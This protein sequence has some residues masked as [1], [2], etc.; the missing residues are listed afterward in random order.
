M[1]IPCP[2]DSA[3]GTLDLQSSSYSLFFP[4]SLWGAVWVSPFFSYRALSSVDLL[5]EHQCLPFT[6]T[7]RPVEPNGILDTDIL[8]YRKAKPCS[9]HCYIHVNQYFRAEL[10]HLSLESHLTACAA[11]VHFRQHMLCSSA[12]HLS[13]HLCSMGAWQNWFYFYPLKN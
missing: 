3:L 11:R 4:A 12:E 2:V 13:L 7:V 5:H 9:I 1:I 10:P 8:G 6:C